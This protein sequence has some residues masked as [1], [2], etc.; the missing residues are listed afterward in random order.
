MDASMAQGGYAAIAQMATG[1]VGAYYSNQVTGIQTRAQNDIRAINNSTTAVQNTRNAAVSSL[2]RW[3]QTVRNSRVQE[4][5]KANQE[6]L[7]VNFNRQRDARTRSNFATNVR[8]AEQS[9][10]QAAAAASSGITGSVVDVINQTSM[11]KKGM[12]NSA[13]LE[14]EAQLGTDYNAQEFAQ[15]WAVLDQLDSGLIF[16]NTQ[17]LD[18]RVSIGQTQNLLTSAIGGTSVKGIQALTTAASSFFQTDYGLGG[19]ASSGTQ[20]MAD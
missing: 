2:Q 16:D 19:L 13:R 15:R 5:V 10:R 1:L 4:A 9:G 7:A 14:T 11:I 17:T 6:A 3:Q 8:E 20:G 18:Y 12:E